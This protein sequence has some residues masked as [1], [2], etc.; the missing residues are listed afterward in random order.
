MKQQNDFLHNPKNAWLLLSLVLA[1]CSDDMYRFRPENLDSG[2]R[3]ELQAS[4]DQVND[5][6]ADEAGFADGDRFGLFVV[7]YKDGIPGALTLSNNQVNNVAMTY[8]ADANSWKS[9]TDIYWV[10]KV[11]PA[12]IYGYYPFFNG[13]S[14]VESYN[15]E[16]KADQSISGGDGEMGSYEASDFLWAKT[17]KASPGKKVELTFGHIMA[18][19]KVVLQ[20]GSGFEG[21]AWSKLTKI[22][23]VDNTIRNA[24]INLQTGIAIPSGDYDRNIVMNPEGD[25]WRAVV[26][27][28]SVAANKSVIGIT[29]DGKPYAY[30]RSDGMT[31]TSGKLHTFT[32]KVDRK[33]DSGDYA[34]TLVNEDITPWEADKSS[35]NFDANSYLV[36]HIEEAGTLKACLEAL[37]Y[38]I[39]NIRNLKVTGNLTEEDFRV[40]REEMGLLTGLNIKDVKIKEVQYY[41]KE[42]RKMIYVDDVLPE[43]AFYDKKSLRRVILPSGLKRLYNECFRGIELNSTLIIPDSVIEIG[44]GAFSRAGGN[45]E[46]ILPANLEIIGYLAFCVCDAKIELRLPSCLKEIGGNAFDRARGVYGKFA[47]PDGLINIG[48]EAFQ[49]CGENLDG[50]IIIPSGINKIPERAFDGMRFSKPVKLSLHDGITSIG[51]RAF[52][53]LKFSEPIKFPESLVEIGDLAFEYCRFVGDLV[54]PSHLLYIGNSAFNRADVRGE[55]ILPEY[56]ERLEGNGVNGSFSNSKIEKIVGE[57]IQ[58]IG[59]GSFANC[60][61]LREVRFGKNIEYIGKNAFLNCEGLQTF[62]CLASEPPTIVD[63]AIDGIDFSHCVLEVPESSVETYRHA[64]VWNRFLSIVP[65]HELNASLSEFS[66]LNKGITRNIRVRAD[67]PWEV[68]DCPEWIH[69]SKDYG[70]GKVETDIKVDALP[71][72]EGDREGIILFRLKENGYTNYITVRQYDY[73]IEEDKKIILSEASGKGNAIPIF[74]VGE[75]YGA[76]AI[77]SGEYMERVNET[78]ESL[79]S[80]EPFKT[81]KDMFTVSTAIALSADNGA[82]DILTS[83]ETI[84]G[85]TFPELPRWWDGYKKL[86]QY[87]E[88]VIGGEEVDNVY[89]SLVIVLANYDAFAGCSDYGNVSNFSVAFIG[90][91]KEIYP[92]DNR[93]LVQYYAG[94]EAFG[95]LATEQVT[96]F[97]FVKGCKC[98]YCDMMP[99]I[100][101][102]KGRG[103]YENISLTNKSDEVPWKDFIYHPKYSSFVDLYEGGADHLRGVWRSEVESVMST[104]VPY[105]NTISRY[106]IYKEIMRRSY[107]TPSLE[108]FIVND[109]IELPNK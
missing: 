10:D 29:I 12:D 61:E 1:G 93:A 14:D 19:V 70:D 99:K 23:T 96:H 80:I 59:E 103:F 106:A 74:I 32:I 49:D 66:C 3:L 55:V 109:I 6:R 83:K 45:F 94:G 90:N 50:D 25:A 77:A 38:D 40:M 18:G 7:N 57:K 21:D 26:V 107:L 63:S 43:K 92:Y 58:I 34:L 22:V 71:F 88:D 79:F 101:E 56:L 72:G 89:Y 87:V 75:G 5:T 42:D 95:H 65:H 91:S 78:V 47:L 13:M 64:D 41:S 98:P 97:E 53:N 86:N 33:V 15:F 51:I 30:T 84:F 2:L 60:K 8:N 100:Q 104:Y 62:I 105:Y 108:D 37:H 52:N 54:L 85:L 4:I 82:S 48:Y 31:Y 11:T 68:V 102:M 81:Y 67:G 17:A 76:E 69:M 20:E 9:A 28:Q 36:V 24:E 35:H 44:G 73:P 46:I 27:P 16:V 39:T